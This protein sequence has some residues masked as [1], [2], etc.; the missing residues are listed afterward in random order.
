MQKWEYKTLFRQR[1]AKGT[2]VRDY[3]DALDWNVRFEENLSEL[4]DE[5]WELVAIVPRSGL[6]G[7]YGA[8]FTSEELWVF[9]RPMILL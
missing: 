4:G 8:G 6:A 9:K 5:G 3:V 2:T 7:T 1:G